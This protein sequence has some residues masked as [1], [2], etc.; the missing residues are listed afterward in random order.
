MSLKRAELGN[1][2]FLQRSVRSLLELHLVSYAN[3]VAS[4]E[5]VQREISLSNFQ[6][7]TGSARDEENLIVSS[8][9]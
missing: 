4:V 3:W 5:K 2:L 1:P 6:R 7:A 8:K 9:E